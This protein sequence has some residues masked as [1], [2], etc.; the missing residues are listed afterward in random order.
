MTERILPFVAFA[1]YGL[2][3]VAILAGLLLNP[4]AVDA[5]WQTFA[6]WPLVG[7][8]LAALLFLPHVLGLW[9]WESG[10]PLVLRLIILAGLA[11]FTFYS[12]WPRK[13]AAP[14]SQAQS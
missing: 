3:W 4:A 2:L 1:V 6:S 9:A 14:V 11:W 5:A 12:F 8:L 10:W 13:K 7:K